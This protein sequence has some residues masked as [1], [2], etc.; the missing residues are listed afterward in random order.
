MSEFNERVVDLVSGIEPGRVVTYGRLAAWAGRPGAARAVGNVLA[1]STGLPWWRVV[2]ANGR[3]A[4][5]KEHVQARLL[6]EEGVVVGNGHVA[7]KPDVGDAVR[8]RTPGS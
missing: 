7:P 4:P 6:R 3:L 1:R 2:A 8:P 5:G